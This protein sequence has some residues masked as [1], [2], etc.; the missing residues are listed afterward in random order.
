MS[1]NRDDIQRLNDYNYEHVTKTFKII[2]NTPGELP[3]YEIIPVNSESS[4]R[5][6]CVII[7]SS[8][9][10]YYQQGLERLVQHIK[11]SD[12]KGHIIYRLGGW[13]D[14]EGGSL[15]LAHVPYA[16]K[17]CLFKEV[18]ALGYKRAFWLDTSILPLVSLNTLFRMTE[19]K[20]YFVMGNTC[21]VGPY[22]NATVAQA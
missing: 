15:V 11:E 12:F 16:F 7:Y 3:K 10:R 21:M 4:D 2:G 17:V 8:F 6:N 9:N 1:G 18:Q 20:G 13:P 14:T 5:E 19:E 22:T